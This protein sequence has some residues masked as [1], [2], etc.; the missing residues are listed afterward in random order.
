[1]KPAARMAIKA[2]GSRT[3]RDLAG[4][5]AKGEVKAWILSQQSQATTNRAAAM[6]LGSPDY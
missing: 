6:A 2:G 5:M 3:P 1:M 4:L